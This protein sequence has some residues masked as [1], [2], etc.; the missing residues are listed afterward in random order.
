[1]RNE[2]KILFQY[3]PKWKLLLFVLATIS[4]ALMGLATALIVQRAAEMQGTSDM[5]KILTFGFIGALLYAYVALAMLFGNVVINS[6]VYSWVVNIKSGLLQSFVCT[7][8]QYSNSEMISTLTNDMDLLYQAYLAQIL[9][10]PFFSVVFF[11][12]LIYMVSQNLV[13]GLLFVVG[14]LSLMLPQLFFNKRLNQLGSNLSEKR[15]EL[16]KVASDSINGRATILRNGSSKP[17]LKLNTQK[18]K[19]AEHAFFWLSTTNNIVF[20]ISTA[21]KTLAEIVPFVI[22]LVMIGNG[23]DLKF[24]VLLALFSAS[25]QLKQPLQQVLYAFSYIQEVKGIRKKIFSLLG[26]K[27]E[28]SENEVASSFDELVVSDLSMNFGEKKI[29]DKLS[30]NVKAGQKVLIRGKSGSGK[31]TLLKLICGELKQNSGDICLLS[32]GEKYP[33]NFKNFGLVGQEPYIFNGTV[34]YNLCLGQNFDDSDLLRVL[35]EVNL[36]Q[37]LDLSTV[38]Q[39]NGEN[40]SGGQKIRLELARFLLRK[41]QLMLVDEVTASLDN[42]TAQKIRDLIFNLPITIIEVAHHIDDES[43]YDDIITFRKE[44]AYESC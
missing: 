13:L 32:H 39:N 4:N 35:R 24:P 11:S 42:E 25:Q 18:I 40:I 6:L 10:V 17:V 5:G 20:S 22:G 7:K 2:L 44:N 38:L 16:L 33:L 37:D 19:A 29:F 12:P 28:Q 14:A 21:L 30:M 36:A 1:M 23:S 9:I 31:S 41:K 34:R 27:I 15:E 3:A 26:S 43:R 8:N